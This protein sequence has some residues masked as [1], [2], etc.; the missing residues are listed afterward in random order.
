M[1]GDEKGIKGAV[2]PA[3]V[4]G[5]FAAHIRRDQRQVLFQINPFKEATTELRTSA[6]RR[7]EIFG[8]HIRRTRF[9]TIRGEV[10]RSARPSP[11]GVTL[12]GHGPPMR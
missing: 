4:R 11:C 7:W 10:S 12:S 6:A 9:E 2:P 1:R 5:V 8:Q 3:P